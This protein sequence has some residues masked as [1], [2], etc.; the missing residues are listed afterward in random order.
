MIAK[1]Y[2]VALAVTSSIILAGF[3]N[4]HADALSVKYHTVYSPNSKQ[5]N[6]YVDSTSGKV[7]KTIPRGSMVETL[8]KH[9]NRYRVKYVDFMDNSHVI[10]GYLAEENMVYKSTAKQTATLRE[11][12]STDSKIIM[13]IPNERPVKILNNGKLSSNFYNVSYNV[14]VSGTD[15]EGI[16]QTGTYPQ[17]GY[18]YKSNVTLDPLINQ[19]LTTKKVT[20]R[21]KANTTSKAV[22]TLKEGTKVRLL[23]Q[24]T[25]YYKVEYSAKY[26]GY[27]PKS[28][29]KSITPKGT[30]LAG[31]DNIQVYKYASS[32]TKLVS[33]PSGT[34]VKIKG[35]MNLFYNVTFTYND[36]V[37][38]GYVDINNM[39]LGSLTGKT[40]VPAYKM[41]TRVNLAEET[42]NIM[43]TKEETVM[44]G[45]KSTYGKELIT[46][47][48]GTQLQVISEGEGSSWAKVNYNGY[49]GYVLKSVL[50]E[51]TGT[52]D[53]QVV[54]RKSASSSDSAILK[55]SNGNTMK[56]R[57]GAKV[58]VLT[59]GKLYNKIQYNKA[60]TTPSGGASGTGIAYVSNSGEYLNFATIGV[61]PTEDEERLAVVKNAFMEL[62]SQYSFGCKVANYDSK[63]PNA[64]NEKVDCS[65]LVLFA[66]RKAMIESGLGYTS[67]QVPRI[68]AIQA[69][70][71][72][73]AQ[74]EPIDGE[75]LSVSANKRT[76]IAQALDA[77]GNKKSG[78][79]SS[80]KLEPGD[81][82][83]LDKHQ[84]D[85]RINKIINNL[86]DNVADHVGI[87]I[88]NNKIISA[89]YDNLYN[90]CIL[91]LNDSQWANEYS[92]GKWEHYK[93]NATPK[94]R[95]FSRNTLDESTLRGE[96][97]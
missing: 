26:V 39:R 14:T 75:Y 85:L 83:F 47:H 32:K 12:S 28:Q 55:D 49:D 63:N 3:S 21:Q 88:G 87:Y 89:D 86:Q 19:A 77:K 74:G 16:T 52:I 40:N 24:T 6:L 34:K 38:N 25:N 4:N 61:I 81:L 22:V 91:D 94:L 20:L 67:G 66:Y 90:V 23:T 79:W 92:I 48:S 30:F 44:R 17:T 8:G 64:I 97:Y 10:T 59:Q 29:V 62:G 69:S 56:L 31:S 80:L 33:V 53:K 9:N 93:A 46:L 37:Y 5:V 65:G 96:D 43:Y 13:E 54:L 45:A 76:P 78:V 2:K 58:T 11:K 71:S 72:L 7:K 95:L 18:T 82:V 35:A 57:K 73:A 41:E 15:A 70:V 51:P 27:I 68:S 42:R 84:K 1:R 36:K 60:D 50:K